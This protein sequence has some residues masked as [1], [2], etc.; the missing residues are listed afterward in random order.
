MVPSISILMRV[1]H[2]AFILFMTASLTLQTVTG[3]ARTELPPSSY[4]EV[5]RNFDN[6]A[7]QYRA[8]K[9]EV[10]KLITV[11][12]TAKPALAMAGE[13]IT[14]TIEA[15]ADKE[16]NPAL[17]IYPRYLESKMG[18]KETIKLA[19]KKA[20]KRGGKDLYK[21][22]FIYK[23]KATG[24]YLV[25]WKCDTGGDVPEF[26]RYFAVVD[27]SY[28]VCSL[29]NGSHIHPAVPDAVFHEFHLPFNFWMQP[30]LIREGWNAGQWADFSRASRQYGD[31][32]AMLI[33][34]SNGLYIKPAPD[35]DANVSGWQVRLSLEKPEVQ[36]LVLERYRKDIWPTLGFDEP[37]ENFHTYGVANGNVKLA[38]ELGYKTVG[39][40]CASQNWQD[41]TFQINHSGMPDRP[42]F[43]SKEDFRKTGDGG[44]KGMVGVQQC[45]RHTALCND[46]N[47]IYSLEPGVLFHPGQKE[48]IP[49]WKE[50]DEA[51]FSN[52]LDFFEAMVQNRL[53]QTVPYIFT[54]G[55]EFGGVFPGVAEAN[56]NF[57]R[58][59]ARKAGEMPLVF[60]TGDD[61]SDF[62]R[63]HYT[64]TPETTCYLPDLFCGNQSNGK[65]PLYPDIIELES[66][67]TKALLRRP[68]LLPYN[69]YD[70]TTDW[71]NIPDWGN[72][73]IPRKAHGYIYPDTDDR[74]RLTPKMIDTRPFAV[75]RRDQETASGTQITLTVT[76]RSAQMGLALGVWDIA[77]EWKAGTGWYETT[78]GCRFVP[79]RAPFTGNLNGVLLA[80]AKAGQNTFTL[81][82][83]TARRAPEQTEVSLNGGGIRGQ[84]FSRDGQ[85]T[86]YLCATGNTTQTLRLQV[87]EGR[88]ARIYSEASAGKGDGLQERNERSDSQIGS[89]GESNRSF[90]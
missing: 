45:Q 29:Q 57:I 67:Q 32:P 20:D 28:A 50:F 12:L 18:Q 58:Q 47:C 30:S 13:R 89:V 23:P 17:E 73:G 68:E 38:R 66:S 70:Y 69:Q 55:I 24:N 77:R 6:F 53:S 40:L 84:V 14:V 3:W 82:I 72:E 44:S 65:P 81:T 78:P 46:Y 15:A 25:H 64:K 87:P 33:W 8:L 22:T 42:F 5:N 4:E 7:K 27:N 88:M 21:A 85:S 1:M 26:W 19:W 54:A 74:F 63:R 62:Y 16:P 11:H 90:A 9:P 37:I 79:V 75:S 43:I 61:V 83:K 2:G 80:D 31:T 39:S 41:G 51:Y 60:T 52:T 59:L 86:A 35:F 48:Y 56:A 36:K 49:S 10:D 76:A 71:K 34:V